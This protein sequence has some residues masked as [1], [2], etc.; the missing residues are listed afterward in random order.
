MIISSAI[1]RRSD[2]A[3]NLPHV[4][5]IKAGEPLPIDASVRPLRGAAVAKTLAARGA[6][7][8]LWASTF[9]HQTKHHVFSEQT[10]MKLGP[11]LTLIALHG[12]AYSANVSAARFRNHRAEAKAFL[13]EAARRPRPDIIVAAMPTLDLAEAAVAFGKANDVPV[14]IDIRDLWPDALLFRLPR[15]LRGP[16]RLALVPFYRQLRRTMRGA[17]AIFAISEG[18][19]DWGLGFAARPRAD[20]DHVFRSAYRPAEID[21][22]AERRALDFW[23]EN[24]ILVDPRPHIAVYA[25]TLTHR[26]GHRLLDVIKSFRSSGS[27]LVNW[28]LVICGAGP[29][30]ADLQS[31]S[32]GDDRIVFPGWLNSPELSVILQH[33]N[34]GLLPYP[35]EPDLLQACPNKFAEYLCHSL[36]VASLLDGEVGR[37]IR[38]T[39]CGW[40]CNDAEAIIEVFRHQVPQQDRLREMRCAARTLFSQSFGGDQ[41][42]DA[43]ADCVE[44]IA[45]TPTSARR[46]H[47][48]NILM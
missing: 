40:V 26:A 15:L 42:F 21:A 19:L 33:S 43:Y 44:T 47:I 9:S 36:P 48:H 7:V 31:A 3:E 24:N 27:D 38:E 18:M 14:I 22:E 11:G 13:R 20:A 46:S 41:V 39:G 37:M 17:S 5:I 10:E 34:V 8:T 23:R 12:P 6:D 30:L 29:L 2:N 32:A 1:P 45:A 16:A 4:W 28:R 25:G 35:N